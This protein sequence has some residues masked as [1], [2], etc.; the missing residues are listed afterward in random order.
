MTH[1]FVSLFGVKFFTANVDGRSVA[2]D[3]HRACKDSRYIACPASAKSKYRTHLLSAI[4]IET[5]ILEHLCEL[6]LRQLTVGET[7]KADA[8]ETATA[9][10]ANL[11]AQLGETEQL[12]VEHPSATLAK[13]AQRLEGQIAAAQKNLTDLRAEA[14]VPACKQD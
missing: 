2:C 14:T 11:Q 13:V 8:V 7:Y 1:S 4:A 10:L 5:A 3:P 6:D 9:K 12:M